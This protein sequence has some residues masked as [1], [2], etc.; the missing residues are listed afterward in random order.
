M[1]R[2][3][4]A[5]LTPLALATAFLSAAG[6]AAPAPQT[7]TL[8]NLQAAYNGE[9]NARATYLAY[10]TKAQKEGYA[11]AAALFRAAAKAEEIHA[12]NHAQVIKALGAEPKADI[13]APEVKSTRENLQAAIKGESYERDVMY[14]GF[15]TQAR[16]E[17]KVD[18]IRTF[19]YAKTAEAEHA[20]L[21]QEALDNL[22]GWKTQNVS[23]YVCP[24]CGY[25]STAR[26]QEKCP[27]SFTPSA[28][29]LTVG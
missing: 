15:L 4:S 23:F 21:Y 20:R 7:G 29:F 25:T 28:R 19:N 8:S 10:A 5:F 24:V 13:K 12:A 6:P 18:A 1:I 16:K 11:K 26:P 17:G 22:D 27:S 9:S 14:P 2:F 3:R